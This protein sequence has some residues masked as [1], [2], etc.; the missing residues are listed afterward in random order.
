MNIGFHSMIRKKTIH[1]N[2]ESDVV[3]MIM[4]LENQK[5]NSIIVVTTHEFMIV[6]SHDQDCDQPRQ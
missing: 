2:I 6:T 3:A 4:H 5:H 1:S